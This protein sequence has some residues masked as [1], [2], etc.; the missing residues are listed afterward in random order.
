MAFCMLSDTESSVHGRPRL[1]RCLRPVRSSAFFC[2]LFVDIAVALAA[3]GIIDPEFVPQPVGRDA[4]NFQ[5]VS[6]LVSLG[7]IA[8]GPVSA[9]QSTGSNPYSHGS[10]V[11]DTK[12]GMTVISANY[13]VKSFIINV[14]VNVC[15][16]FFLTIHNKAMCSCV[17]QITAGKDPAKALLICTSQLYQGLSG[18]K[19]PAG[20]GFC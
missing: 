3:A 18:V 2:I 10:N 12:S 6:V 11:S 20:G 19:N 1:C 4:I 16:V 5:P 17:A 7:D 14:V 15:H 9:V 8:I 13:L